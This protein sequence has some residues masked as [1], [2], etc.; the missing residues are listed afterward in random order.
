VYVFPQ[1][2]VELGRAD[3]AGAIIDEL[4]TQTGNREPFLA[5]AVQAFAA[6]RHAEGVAA[7]IAQTERR[8]IVDPEGLFYVGRHLAHVGELDKAMPLIERSV[9]GGYSCYTVMARDSWLDALRSRAEFQSAV[10]A[11]KMRWE[12]ASAAFAAAGG[13]R[14]LGMLTL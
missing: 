12:R 5:K 7:L 10:G 3:E 9:Q 2:L 6:G 11:A 8:G 13:A 4:E 14:L 1:S